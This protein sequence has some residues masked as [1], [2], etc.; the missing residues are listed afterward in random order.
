M[1]NNTLLR[2]LMIASYVNGETKATR[3]CNCWRPALCV[4]YRLAQPTF[5]N[6]LKKGEPLGSLFFSHIKQSASRRAP[7]ARI[8]ACRNVP[9]PIRVIDTLPCNGPAYRRL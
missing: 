5:T 7:F 1:A 6:T 2:L 8:G 9:A 4:R 3:F